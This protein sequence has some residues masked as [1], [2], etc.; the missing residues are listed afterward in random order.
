MSGARHVGS[1][2]RLKTRSGTLEGPSSPLALRKEEQGEARP[3]TTGCRSPVYT[4]K[5]SDS[6]PAHRGW[7]RVHRSTTLGVCRHLG[8]RSEARA[9]RVPLPPDGSSSCAGAKSLSK[10]HAAPRATRL[11][12][13]SW[14]TEVRRHG[15]PS[16]PT[17]LQTCRRSVEGTS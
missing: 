3:P 6:P 4:T 13:Y 11:S 9:G 8:S 10:G 16:D 1:Y 17:S 15:R 14:A 7:G 5:L 12:V 2:T